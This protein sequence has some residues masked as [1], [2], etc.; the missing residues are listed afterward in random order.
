MYLKGRVIERDRET[1]IFHPL[2]HNSQGWA[3]LKPES[4]GLNSGPSIGGRY[5]ILES[6]YA[7]FQGAQ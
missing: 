6:S 1:D 3:R 2:V 7:A 5:Q 4:P